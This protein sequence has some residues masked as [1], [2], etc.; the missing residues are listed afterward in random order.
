MKRVERS[1]QKESAPQT[2]FSTMSFGMLIFLFSLPGLFVCVLSEGGI[3][4]TKGRRE[5]YL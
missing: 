2:R 4:G 1:T 5:F 3:N